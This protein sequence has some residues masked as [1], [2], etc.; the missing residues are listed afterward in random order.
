MGQDIDIRIDY[1]QLKITILT[2]MNTSDIRKNFILT[3]TGQ[4]KYL[5][6]IGES[7]IL[8]YCF[9]NFD[10]IYEYIS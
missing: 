10:I 8:A 4:L 6:V 1:Y 2:K 5:F 9:L 3:T 7:R